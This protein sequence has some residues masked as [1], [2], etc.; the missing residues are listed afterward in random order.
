[1]KKRGLLSFWLIAALAWFAPANVHANEQNLLVNGDFSANGGG[2]N[3]ASGGAE[4]ANGIPS[5]GVWGGQ[6]QLTFSYMQNSVSQ[7]VTIHSPSALE[8]SFLANGPN[9]GTYSATISD[10]NESATTG[11][12]TAG[13]NQ[14]SNLA[15]TT[16]QND[17]VVTITFAGKDSLFWAGCYGPV[18]RSA[19][20]AVVTQPTS[21][22]VTSL[23]D[24]GS[25]G[26]LRWAITQANATS[27][28]IY[29]SIQIPAGTITLSSAL[30]NITQNVTIIGSGQTSTVIDGD[31]QFRIFNVNNYISLT[32]SD[33]T[34]KRGQNTNGGLIYNN[35]GTVIADRVRFTSMTGGSAV[36]N[37]NGGAVSYYTDSTWDSLSIGIAGDYGSTPQL[38]SGITSWATTDDSVFQ[39][40]T[41]VTRGTF[42]NNTHG[43]YNYRFTKVIDSTFANNSGTAANV[44]GLNRT[45]IINSVFTNNGTAIYHSA[46][47]PTGWNMGTDNRLISGN[48]FTDNTTAIYLDDGW[49][50]GQR[51]QSWSTI[52]N[53]IWSGT[54]AWITYQ[55]WDG[56]NNIEYSAIPSTEGTPFTQ[57]NNTIPLPPTT[58]TTTTTTTTIA[59]TTT[60]TTEPEPETTTTSEPEPETTTTEPEP[61]ITEPETTLPPDTIPFVPDTTDGGP[62]GGTGDSADTTSPET[63]VPQPA[64]EE[65]TPDTTLDTPI[66]DPDAGQVVDDIL[67]EDPSPDE[68]ADAVENALSATESEEELVSVATELLASDLDPE[69]F[70]AVVAEVFSQDLSDEALTE[71]V[72]EVFSQNLS[73]EEIAAVVDQV[74][75][76]DI[77]DEA[78]AEVLDAVFEEPLSDEAFTSVIDA[79]LDEPISDEAFD[80]LVDVLGS[81]TVSDEQVVAAVDAIIENGLSEAQSV[82]IATSGEVL[83]SITG[84]QASEIFNTVPIG[85]IA[86]AEAVALVEAVQDA[87]TEVKEAFETEIN[88]FAAGNVDTYVPLGSEVPV[89]TRRVIIA[90]TA[91]VVAVAPA[92]VSRK[93]R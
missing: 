29:D 48:T 69:Q 70:A 92:P 14:V 71:L 84:D 42:E 40:R 24:D 35:R 77:S 4:C 11:V 63:T 28:G 39:N 58:T 51:N 67:A 62:D 60:I 93:G 56:F 73:D 16:T 55:Q 18:I 19:S 12:L 3:G 86:D 25:V 83:E 41:Y 7:E 74:F 21:L 54:G 61:V 38:A 80:E 50:N 87:P 47:I 10:S 30:P 78:F 26:T 59:P 5:L 1:M 79:I 31:S 76:A 75:T 2:W 43:I 8:L 64:P 23:L 17:E 37:N 36:F 22:V 9:G 68:L 32:V 90:A 82:S 81:D 13:A 88:I 46:W 66:E 85:E 34:L 20:L 27:G 65:E 72:T 45:Q 53:N 44:T 91:V 57:L 89:G 6:P 52:S 49:N 15:V 33:L